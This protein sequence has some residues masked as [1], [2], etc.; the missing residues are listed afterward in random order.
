MTLTNIFISFNQHKSSNISEG[1]SAEH[2]PTTNITVALIY[3]SD[4]ENER[5]AIFN[6]KCELA[7]KTSQLCAIQYNISNN[8]L[9]FILFVLKFTVKFN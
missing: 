4:F 9:I 1:N 3:V 8:M 2:E 7:A 6:S 5:K